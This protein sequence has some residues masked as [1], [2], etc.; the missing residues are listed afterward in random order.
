MELGPYGCFNM[1]QRTVCALAGSHGVA[2]G[3]TG[4]GG[5]CSVILAHD[6]PFSTTTSGIPVPAHPFHTVSC[7]ITVGAVV[8]EHLHRFQFCFAGS[9]RLDNAKNFFQQNYAS[10]RVQVHVFRPEI[11]DLYSI[12]R[13]DP[14][15]SSSC[16]IQVPKSTFCPLSPPAIAEAISLFVCT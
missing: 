16:G 10:F 12:F 3:G 2:L 8:F 15:R 5:T 14:P 6:P 13:W 1:A 11:F 9:L 4:V 7:S